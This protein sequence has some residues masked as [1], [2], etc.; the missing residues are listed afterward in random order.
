MN[1]RA[2]RAAAGHRVACAGATGTAIDF[3]SD[4][5]LSEPLPRTFE[6]WA[7]YLQ[8]TPA[9]AVY[10]LGDLFEFWPGSDAVALRLRAALCRRC[11]REA[12]QQRHVAFMVGNRDFLRR[13]RHAGGIAACS[14]LPDPT[15]LSAWRHRAAAD[16]WR[17]AVPGRPALPA[18]P[19]QDAQPGDA[20]RLSGAAAGRARAMGAGIRHASEASRRQKPP[21]GRLGRRRR[22]RRGRLAARRRRDANGARPHPSTGRFDAGTGLRRA[23]CSATGISTAH[24]PRAEV[25]RLRRDGFSAAGARPTRCSPVMAPLVGP[26]AAAQ[27]SSARLQRRAIPDA[28]WR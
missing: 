23:R 28:L 26:A 19:R 20:A 4:L 27:R 13:R 2:E 3:I 8:R 9:D 22:R 16:A 17:C 25:L 5:H 11:W 21:P 12:A 14:R 24:A 6:A 1:H 10:I 15:L 7:D 18:V